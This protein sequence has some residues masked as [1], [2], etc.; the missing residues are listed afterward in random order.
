MSE[1]LDHLRSCVGADHVRSEGD[2]AAWECDWSGSYQG[3]ALAVVLPSSAQQ[4]ADV[5]KA[6][7]RA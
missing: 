1:L 3:K 4:V 6:C 5:V 2:L 7:A